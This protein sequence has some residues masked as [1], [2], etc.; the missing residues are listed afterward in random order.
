MPWQSVTRTWKIHKETSNRETFPQVAW[1]PALAKDEEEGREVET[2]GYEQYANNPSLR[3]SH[4]RNNSGQCKILTPT[5]NYAKQFV[6]CTRTMHTTLGNVTACLL[7]DF[8]FSWLRFLSVF[9]N[10][11]VADTFELMG[12]ILS[13]RIQNPWTL[14]E[15]HVNYKP[16]LTRHSCQCQIN[17]GQLRSLP[18]VSHNWTSLHLETPFWTAN[19]RKSFFLKPPVSG[20]GAGVRISFSSFQQTLTENPFKLFSRSGK[21]TNPFSLNCSALD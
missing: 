19:V 11:V 13:F 12:L 17:T 16:S 7:T 5:N 1:K 8:S 20:A 4:I 15:I 14:V 2:G 9:L 21:W 3:R 6:F 10:L 18:C